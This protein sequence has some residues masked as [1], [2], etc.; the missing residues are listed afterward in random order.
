MGFE[1]SGRDVFYN[2]IYYPLQKT[3]EHDYLSKKIELLI[4]GCFFQMLYATNT[5]YEYGFE[6]CAFTKLNEPRETTSKK[7][8]DKVWRS[9]LIDVLLR[10]I[11]NLSNVSMVT[12]EKV[13]L[14]KYLFSKIGHVNNFENSSQDYIHLGSH[15]YNENRQCSKKTD[16]PKLDRF[17]EKIKNKTYLS[18]SEKQEK[19]EKEEQ[20]KINEQKELELREGEITKNINYETIKTNHIKKET[21]KKLELYPQELIDKVIYNY[22]SKKLSEDKKEIDNEVESKISEEINNRIK[23]NLNKIMNQFSLF[24][25]NKE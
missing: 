22:L 15:T 17:I 7:S 3:Q 1:I 23:N 25:E 9:Q 21:N 8:I 2:N 6:I 20:Q 19:K 12:E 18:S 13:A 16:I 14:E 24:I 10:G 11:I 5:D 4:D